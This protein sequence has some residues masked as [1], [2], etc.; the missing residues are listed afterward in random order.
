MYVLIYFFCYFPYQIF[1]V[2]ELNDLLNCLANFQEIGNGFSV[3]FFFANSNT[4]LLAVCTHFF[5]FSTHRVTSFLAVFI[6]TD[7]VSKDFVIN[8]ISV[9][10]PE[11]VYE[12]ADWITR[13]VLSIHIDYMLEI[14]KWQ[15]DFFHNP[16]L[17]RGCFSSLVFKRFGLLYKQ[18]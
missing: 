15:T 8:V 14:F 12:F 16:S 5:Y 9:C 4:F 7:G 18:K 2:V 3:G 17:E 13:L 11:V 10:T 6:I 1:G